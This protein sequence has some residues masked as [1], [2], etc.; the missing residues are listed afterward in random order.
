MQKIVLLWTLQAQTSITGVGGWLELAS[1]GRKVLGKW[2]AEL[3]SSATHKQEFFGYHLHPLNSGCAS[4]PDT[5]STCRRC[6]KEASSNK[7][8]HSS[9]TSRKSKSSKAKGKGKGQGHE[10]SDEEASSQ[11]MKP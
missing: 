9:C 3:A 1:S 10:G 5:T 8:K 6:S 4:S 11:E 2:V 7:A